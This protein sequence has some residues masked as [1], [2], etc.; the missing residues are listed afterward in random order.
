MGPSDSASEI[1]LWKI[2]SGG[3]SSYIAKT[4]GILKC[5]AVSATSTGWEWPVRDVPGGIGAAVSPK[6]VGESSRHLG[7]R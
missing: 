7:N 2:S 6:R 1:L 5:L 3:V 4:T